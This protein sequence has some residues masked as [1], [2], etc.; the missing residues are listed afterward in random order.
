MLSWLLDSDLSRL[1]KH[2]K[3]L[4]MSQSRKPWLWIALTLIAALTSMMVCFDVMHCARP[5][6]L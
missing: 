6:G 2:L 4:S 3:V 1:G 5:V